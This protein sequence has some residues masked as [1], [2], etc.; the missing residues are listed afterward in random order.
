VQ[1]SII[2]KYKKRE[3]VLS[4]T[5]P[6]WRL[7]LGRNIFSLRWQNLRKHILKQLSSSSENNLPNQDVLTRLLAASWIFCV[8]KTS[9]ELIRAIDHQF[10]I[11][12][13]AATAN[14]LQKKAQS[15]ETE[16]TEFGNKLHTLN[17]AN[18]N[19]A[20]LE[21]TMIQSINALYQLIQESKKPCYSPPQ[22][23]SEQQSK[24]III[25]AAYEIM[26][27]TGKWLET[28]L[29]YFLSYAYVPMEKLKDSKKRFK[30]LWS[31]LNQ[32]APTLTKHWQDNLP[33]ILAELEEKYADAEDFDNDSIETTTEITTEITTGI[34]KRIT[35]KTIKEITRKTGE[36][37]SKLLFADLYEQSGQ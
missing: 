7:F 27:K 22:K 32:K 11:L 25:P 21:K 4:W 15:F 26:I 10:V 2:E 31:L 17:L 1:H 35:R 28:E 3:V 16:L 23:Q 20:N 13:A 9:F 29:I 18:L 19:I 33:F 5:P 24:F 8:L 30:E 37:L 14:E 34:T 6:D 12:E 36:P